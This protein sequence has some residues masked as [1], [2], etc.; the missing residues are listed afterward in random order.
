MTE[1]RA[2]VETHRSTMVILLLLTLIAAT[3]VV[4]AATGQ[5]DLGGG[6]PSAGDGVIHTSD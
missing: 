5:F 1:A 2:F 4:M 6:T 3:L